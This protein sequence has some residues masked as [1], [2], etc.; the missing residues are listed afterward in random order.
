MECSLALY[1]H[2]LDCLFLRK[3]KKTKSCAGKI[4]FISMKSFNH[5][6]NLFSFQVTP[7]EIFH[8]SSGMIC[9][10]C[11]FS[12]HIKTFTEKFR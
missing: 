1:C 12:R 4:F 11:L 10:V 7:T 2:K 3:K 5:S 8:S 6:V 9:H